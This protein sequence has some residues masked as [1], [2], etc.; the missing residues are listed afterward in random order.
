MHPRFKLDADSKYLQL[1]WLEMTKKR[2]T[3]IFK[4][5][6]WG[7]RIYLIQKLTPQNFFVWGPKGLKSTLPL[8]QWLDGPVH[9][10]YI[11]IYKNIYPQTNHKA[12][13]YD[14]YKW[15]E[16]S[17]ISRVTIPVTHLF[18]ASHRGLMISPF[19]SGVTGG[20]NCLGCFLFLLFWGTPYT[21]TYAMLTCIV[22]FIT[23]LYSWTP[24]T[25]VHDNVWLKT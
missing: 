18:S 15:G 21:W 12:G 22:S 7:S 5:V 10:L 8:V 16:T 6:L 20:V 11:K 24:Q 13:P 4:L 2:K 14:R 23:L 25:C 3:T 17:P 1:K 9:L 19:T